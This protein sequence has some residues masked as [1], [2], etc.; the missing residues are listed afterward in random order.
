LGL[1]ETLLEDCRGIY[2]PPP[3]SVAVVLLLAANDGHGNWLRIGTK[4]FRIVGYYRDSPRNRPKSEESSFMRGKLQ[5]YST[6]NG[7]MLRG[8]AEDLLRRPE[9][10]P[11]LGRVQLIFTSPPFPLHRKK[12]YGNLQ[13]EAYIEWLAAF[14]PLFK[15]LLRPTGSLVVEVGNAWEPGRPVMST[16]PTRALLRLLE[17]SD[18]RLCEQFVSYNAARLP[19]PAQWVNIERIRVKDAFTHVWWMSPSD[20]PYADNRRVLVEYSAAMKKLLRTKQYDAGLRPSGHRI[21]KKSF[22]K[23]NRGAIPSNVVV[24][25][26][27]SSTDLYHR[28]CRAGELTLHPARMPD[29]VADFFV[30]LLTKRGDLILDPFAGSNTTGAAAERLR[31]RW[32]S[33][34]PTEDYIEGSRGRFTKTSRFSVRALSRLVKKRQKKSTTPTVS[35]VVA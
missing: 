30:K 28:H 6:A 7:V 23:N 14:A 5:G 33:I 15:A 3:T 18:F 12:K 31:R 8:L 9:L 25:S 10:K 35:R 24:A 27:T 22:L 16:L 20:R 17:R 2:V 19:G 4:G 34:E 13:G 11:L 1:I 26:N 32:L 21:G 29:A